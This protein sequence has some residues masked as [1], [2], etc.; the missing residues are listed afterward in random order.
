MGQG[1]DCQPHFDH[2]DGHR[3]ASYA[4]HAAQVG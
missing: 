1:I 4:I 3:K 2:Q